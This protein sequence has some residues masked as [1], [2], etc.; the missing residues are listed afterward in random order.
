MYQS[1]YWHSLFSVYWR[2]G[3]NKSIWCCLCGLY[4]SHSIE[5]IFSI[6]SD[7]VVVNIISWPLCKWYIWSSNGNIR[8]LTLRTDCFY[9][10]TSSYDIQ[11]PSRAKCST[12]H[13]DPKTWSNSTAK[14][15]RIGGKEYNGLAA[16]TMV[17]AILRDLVI[18]GINAC[19][20]KTE[21]EGS[22]FLLSLLFAI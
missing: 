6:K 19:N 21:L 17:W 12:S 16:W 3:G 18:E 9:L 20:N 11:N 15:N 5:R 7:G 8:L 1:S 14:P 22:H 10:V 4:N 2:Q 13:R